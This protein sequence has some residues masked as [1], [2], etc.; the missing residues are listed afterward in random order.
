MFTPFGEGVRMVMDGQADMWFTGGSMYP[1]HQ[2]I[3]I[4]SKMP[5]RMVPISKEVAEKAGSEFGQEVIEVPADIYGSNNG[6][7]TTYWSPATMVTFGVRTDMPDDLVYAMTKALA[8]N[9]EK[10]HA[11]HPQH[12]FY[13]PKVAWRNVGGVPLHPGA[14]KFYREAGYMK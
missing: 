3:K 5:F 14:E 7:N 9:I 1:H 6:T 13:D 4:G 11:V 10:F 8:D 12:Q 2:F